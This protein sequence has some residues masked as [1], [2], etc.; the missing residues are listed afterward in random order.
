M[1][2]N[3]AK[4]IQDKIL[5]FQ[6]DLRNSSEI[7]E[8]AEFEKIYNA[9]NYQRSGEDVMKHSDLGKAYRIKRGQLENELKESFS[10]IELMDD[11]M[12]SELDRALYWDI[13]MDM[14]TV[15]TH[16]VWELIAIKYVEM[17]QDD[18]P[19]KM[20]DQS[21]AREDIKDMNNVEFAYFVKDFLDSNGFD[22][23][24]LAYNVDRKG[25]VSAKYV[26]SR[27]VAPSSKQTYSR[28]TES[29]EVIKNRQLFNI[30]QR[31]KEAVSNRIKSY[32]EP[33][34]KQH[35]MTQSTSV[36]SKKK[37]NKSPKM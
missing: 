29:P 22:H 14:S 18:I 10:I 32:F 12:I 30:T 27:Y 11:S 21:L 16:K 33:I 7:K 2:E 3:T 1:N 24:G 15:T 37:K 31:L 35:N 34:V 5:Q 20:N 8:L 26:K 9:P 13:L 6:T 36:K 19:A 17:N 25:N 4:S 23:S 28:S